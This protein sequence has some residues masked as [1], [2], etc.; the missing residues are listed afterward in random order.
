MKWVKNELYQD[1]EDSLIGEFV[2]S[3]SPKKD[4]AECTELGN[5]ECR[6]YKLESST[7]I[8]YSIDI[9]VKDYN[10]EKINSLRKLL[11]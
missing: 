3:Y 5:S 2:K 7:E 6:L 4:T 9:A 11:D 10:P 1:N 8:E